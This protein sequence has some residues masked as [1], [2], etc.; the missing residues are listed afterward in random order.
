MKYLGRRRFDYF[1]GKISTTLLPACDISISDMV[2]KEGP[3]NIR[4]PSEQIVIIDGPHLFASISKIRGVFQAVYGPHGWVHRRFRISVALFK[5][6]RSL[7]PHE[8]LV[9]RKQK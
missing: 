3:R 8:I 2:T 7:S 6:G 9:I 5:E 1:L 4:E